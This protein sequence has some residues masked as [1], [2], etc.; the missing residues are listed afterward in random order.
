MTLNLRGGTIKADATIFEAWTCTASC[1][2]DQRW[3]GTVTSATR[4][5]HELV[6][7]SVSGG[8]LAT[9]DLEAGAVVA[10]DEVLVIT[11]TKSHDGDRSGMG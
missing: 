1:A 7:G 5:F 9:L 11:P 8:G 3:S 10:I 4:R 2:I 6:G